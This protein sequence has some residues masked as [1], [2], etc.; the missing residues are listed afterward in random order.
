MR[1]Q[2]VIRAPAAPFALFALART[3]GWLAHAI[4]R[5]RPAP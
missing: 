4:D 5:P 1:P 2:M 3:A